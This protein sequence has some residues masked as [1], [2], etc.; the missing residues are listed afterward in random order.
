MYILTI[1]LLVVMAIPCLVLAWVFYRQ[2]GR[3]KKR[4]RLAVVEAD[5]WLSRSSYW[6]DATAFTWLH[7]TGWQALP[8]GAPKGLPTAVVHVLAQTAKAGGFIQTT[9]MPKKTGRDWLKEALAMASSR[10]GAYLRLCQKRGNPLTAYNFAIWLEL[11]SQLSAGKSSWKN[12]LK[13]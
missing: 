3:L 2:T 7:K 4:Q 9:E 12:L 13:G 1:L 10:P 5:S 8:F 6:S 11:E